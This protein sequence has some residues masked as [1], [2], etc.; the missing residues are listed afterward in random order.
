MNMQVSS[1]SPAGIVRA[2]KLGVKRILGVVPQ[3]MVTP[4][5]RLEWLGSES[6]GYYVPVGLLD[7]GSICYCVGAGQDITFD[8]ELARIHGCQVLVFDPTP[9]SYE[10]FEAVQDAVRRGV[11][12]GVVEGRPFQYRIDAERLRLL[13]FVALGVCETPGI[14][15]FYEPLRK[16]YLGRSVEL[17][18]ES[19]R[20]LELPVDRLSRIMAREGHAAIDLLKLE[21]EGSEYGVIRSLV[22]DRLD[23]KAVLVEYDEVYHARN[24]AH[25][26]RIRASTKLLLAAGYRLAHSTNSFKRLFVRGDVFDRL[27]QAGR[28]AL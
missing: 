12:L 11:P 14:M 16:N 10:H 13:R 27:A 17:F 2:A 4:L 18:R 15:R 20:Y 9:E 28:S 24:S 1:S 8:T 23:I 3:S 7:A 26:F 21:I 19:G 22:E 5:A 6:H 25:L